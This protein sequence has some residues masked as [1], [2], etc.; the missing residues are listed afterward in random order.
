M[1]QCT[2][3]IFISRGNIVSIFLEL[4][5]HSANMIPLEQQLCFLLPY[6]PS[7]HHSTPFSWVWLILD[8]S[9]KCNH[10]VIF[11]PCLSYFTQHN[12]LHVHSRCLMVEFSCLSWFNIPLHAYTIFP[13]SNHLSMDHLQILA[14][15][16]NAAMNMASYLLIILISVILDLYPEVGLLDHIEIILFFWEITILFSLVFAEFGSVSKY[17]PLE[18]KFVDRSIMGLLKTVCLGEIPLN[19]TW[20]QW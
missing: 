3:S 13:L 4:I 19:V 5:L 11:F 9:L 18:D 8:N 15:V 20:K 7:N 14:V 12:V 17:N 16:Y 1:F 2:Y 6:P 10:T